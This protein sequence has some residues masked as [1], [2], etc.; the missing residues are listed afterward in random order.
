M[1]VQH[2]N[3]RFLFLLCQGLIQ[4]NI[5]MLLTPMEEDVQMA[6]KLGSFL[7]VSSCPVIRP[8]DHQTAAV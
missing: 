8:L 1:K 6:M 3:H 2:F 7:Y 4:E 5:L